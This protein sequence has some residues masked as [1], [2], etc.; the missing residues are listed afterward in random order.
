M[1]Y[2]SN[3]VTIVVEERP[4]EAVEEIKWEKVFERTYP[5]AYTYTGKAIYE[6]VAFLVDPLKILG[7]WREW[8]STELP[9]EIESR[10]EE[11]GLKL[12]KLE[13]YVGS[14]PILWG[15]ASYPAVRVVSIYHHPVPA[16]VYA[17][18]AIILAILVTIAII[19]HVVREIDWEAIGRTMV[20]V[21]FGLLLPIIAGVL[22]IYAITRRKE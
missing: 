12:I 4:A 17:L 14:K 20:E 13:V 18:L 16:A 21:G 15:L 2:T 1:A 3:E 7:G 10:M 5:E 6:E 9:K 19:L 11:E 22:I 8:A